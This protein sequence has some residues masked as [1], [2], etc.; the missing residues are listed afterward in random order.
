MAARRRHPT[1]ILVTA[2]RGHFHY[3]HQAP[4]GSHKCPGGFGML[5]GGAGCVLDRLG[6]SGG[7]PVTVADPRELIVAWNDPSTQRRAVARRKKARRVWRLAGVT[8]DCTQRRRGC[9]RCSAPRRR[10]GRCD[11]RRCSMTS[12]P[13]NLGLF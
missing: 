2:A 4:S 5:M 12:P 7:P 3:P 6:G 11:F 10:G 1:K 9:R 8:W 13:S